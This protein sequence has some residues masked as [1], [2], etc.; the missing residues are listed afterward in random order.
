M[1]LIK[2]FLFFLLLVMFTNMVLFVIIWIAFFP[3]K[4]DFK[5]MFRENGYNYN[6][7]DGK[8]NLGYKH[9]NLMMESC[10][11]EISKLKP[12]ETK[13]FQKVWRTIRK[14]LVGMF[15]ITVLF[16]CVTILFVS[17]RYSSR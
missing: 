1:I 5:K 8:K 2:C 11:N 4:D 9:F 17:T 10:C 6:Y 3:L 14:I 13:R 16:T 15:S 12:M 7:Y